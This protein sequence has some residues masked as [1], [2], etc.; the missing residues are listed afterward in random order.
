[1][2]ASASQTVALAVCSMGALSLPLGYVPLAL[3]TGP[4]ALAAAVPTDWSFRMLVTIRAARDQ[5][6]PCG[7]GSVRSHAS[8]E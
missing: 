3:L 2:R 6:V 1:M 5:V 7:G 8:G 4:T